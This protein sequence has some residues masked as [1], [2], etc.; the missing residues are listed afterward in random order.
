[1]LQALAR[2]NISF[3]FSIIFAS[4]GFSVLLFAFVSHT[5]SDIAGTVV[6]VASGAIIDAIS[7]RFFVQSTNAQKSMSE[8]FEKLRLDRLNA[9]AREMI[10]EIESVPMRDQLRSQL[11]LKYSGID[12]LLDGSR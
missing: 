8:F 4:I 11:I 2:A 1:M 5:S 7:V 10:A 9:E 6:K 3:W 12:K